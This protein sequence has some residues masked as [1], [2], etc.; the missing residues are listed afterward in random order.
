MAIID[1]K[2]RGGRKQIRAMVN[3]ELVVIKRASR[4]G[5]TLGI[6]LPREWIMALEIKHN[7]KPEK[8]MLDYNAEVMT[9]RPYFGEEG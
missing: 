6:F 8:F 3:G 4:F 7:R 9:I 1:L 5:E 2:P